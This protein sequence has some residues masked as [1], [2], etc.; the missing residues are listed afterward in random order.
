MVTMDLYRI[1]ALLWRLAAVLAAATAASAAAMALWPMNMTGS[2][3]AS[4]GSPT[5]LPADA[6]GEGDRRLDH[7]AV[8]WQRPLRGPLYDPPPVVVVKVPPPEPKFEYK[9]TG[10]VVEEG[11]SFATFADGRG[12]TVLRRVGQA[13]GE[14]EV[15]SIS[16]DSAEVL[17]AG[18]L[19]TVP[20]EK[21]KSSP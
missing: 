14:A 9:L 5:T 11:F 4:A 13:I 17:L 15:K 12:K 10:A 18:K 6:E 21:P 2:G 8:L 20:L 1:K 3:G 19:L 16:A 7:Y